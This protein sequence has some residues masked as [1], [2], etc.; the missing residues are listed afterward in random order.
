M[1]SLSLSVSVK[2]TGRVWAPLCIVHL[3]VASLVAS[4]FNCALVLFEGLAK[5]I[6]NPGNELVLLADLM[7]GMLAV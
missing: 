3:V 4:L 6:G 1:V 2:D 5:S 7:V